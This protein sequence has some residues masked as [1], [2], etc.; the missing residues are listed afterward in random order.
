MGG[1][2]SGQA[3]PAR[4]GGDAMTRDEITKEQAW[5]LLAYVVDHAADHD[6]ECPGD[7]TCECSFY[8][9]NAAVNA[10]V[11]ALIESPAQVAAPPAGVLDGPRPTTAL[12]R[13]YA[14]ALDVINQ[15]REE[16]DRLRAA[17][18]AD[19]VATCEWSED[20]NGEWHTGCGT[21]FVFDTDGP[22][23]HKFGWCY[24]CGKPLAPVPFLLPEAP[25]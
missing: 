9:R 21:L 3:R 23:E 6:D 14:K 2:E 25:K 17:P 4:H 13:E 15:Q 8:A 19:L 5:H 7:S 10:V 1:A 20:A 12:D 24:H 22:T 16:L 11:K 18:P